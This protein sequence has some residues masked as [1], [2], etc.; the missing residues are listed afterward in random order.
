M[1]SAVFCLAL[2]EALLRLFPGV[3]PPEVRQLVEDGPNNQGVSHPY[4]GHLQT[5]NKT[6]V[7]S[8]TDF[9]ATHHVD[10]FGFRNAWP[11]PEKADI[12]VLGDSVTFGQAVADERA[13]PAILAH[14]LPKSHVINLGL[15]GAGGQQYLR[16]Y[17]T[18][19]TN[20]RPKVLLVGFFARNDFWDDGMFDRWLEAGVG[21]NYMVWRNFGRPRR[22]SFTL[23]R[24]IG[25]LMDALRWNH[26]LFSRSS[27]LYTLLLHA[28]GVVQKW[29]PAEAKVFKFPDGARMELFPGD[30]AKNTVGAERHRRE[31]QLALQALQRIQSIATANGT[32]VLVIF[33][34]SKEEVYLPLLGDPSSDPA[35]PLQ[36]E[37]KKLGIACLD[38]MPAFRER[39]EA[40]EKLFFEAD[41]HPNVRGYALIAERVF[42]HLKDNAKKYGL[43]DWQT[44]SSHARS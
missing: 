31:F 42:S 36:E 37:L 6:F 13:W 1:G 21:G 40:G 30:F 8:G 10:G 11:W 26:A 7:V 2:A 19:G 33:Q 41:G 35:G 28:R 16:V 34:P 38:L 15:V 24:P 29:R 23:E 17:E 18:F 14:A 27:Y 12:V 3:L 39:A 32:H 25:S 44:T 20:L 43:T 5:P 4:I 22:I 9:T